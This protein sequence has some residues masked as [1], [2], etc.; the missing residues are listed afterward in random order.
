MSLAD[1]SLESFI[2]GDSAAALVRLSEQVGKG[3]LCGLW[4]P[5]QFHQPDFPARLI[6]GLSRIL[7]P[8]PTPGWQRDRGESVGERGTPQAHAGNGCL[9][10]AF[11]VVIFLAYGKECLPGKA[12]SSQRGALTESPSHLG[13]SHI[14]V[15]FLSSH[16]V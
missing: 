1:L 16:S 7:A 4:F 12:G 2:S 9:W 15:T 5:S 10:V 6:C 3:L 11:A 8:L 13:R 14:L